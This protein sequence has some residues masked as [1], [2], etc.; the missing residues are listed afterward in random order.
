M[1]TEEVQIILKGEFKNKQAVIDALKGIDKGVKD[2][3][4]QSDKT[5]KKVNS[6]ESSLKKLAK[7]V[8]LSILAK[9]FIDLGK[10][11]LTAAGQM[12]QYNVAFTTMLGSAEKAKNLMEEAIEFAAK[13]PFQLDGVLDATKQLLAYQVAQEEVLPTLRNLGDI[14]AGTGA[15]L[16]LIAKA[17]GDIKTKGKL[18]GQEVLQL[19]NANIPIIKELAKTFGLT[20]TEI[21]NM[22]AKGQI[23]FEMVK[24]AIRG[25][26]AEGG[27]FFNLMDEQSKTFL[28]TVSNMQDGFF[29]LKVS[30][31]N[32]LLPV[33][34]ETVNKL[35]ILFDRLTKIVDKNKEKIT[36]FARSFKKAIGAGIEILSTFI[37]GIKFLISV[38]FIKWLGLTT[39]AVYAL[40]KALILIT[41][42]PILFFIISI[43]QLIG[44]TV[45]A[46]DS[47]LNGTGKIP[48]IFQKSLLIAAKAF[49]EL[50]LAVTAAV[51]AILEKLSF[52]SK[53]PGFGWVD[54]AIDKFDK[55][56]KS[57]ID[58]INDIQT[59]IDK[60]NE[61]KFDAEDEQIKDVETPEAKEAKKDNTVAL[62]Q[63]ENEELL[64]LEENFLA[65]KISLREKEAGI[66]DINRQER[67]AKLNQ[68]YADKILQE[69]LTNEQLLALRQEHFEA[70]REINAQKNEDLL[71]AEAD[72]IEG[73]LTQKEFEAE[74]NAIKR[75]E[76][77]ALLREDMALRLEDQIL[78]NE[79]R[80][81]L[82]E[83][84]E[85]RKKGI[86]DKYR[87]QKSVADKLQ[88]AIDIKNKQVKDST[89]WKTSDSLAKSLVGLESNKNSQLRS[90]GKA[91]GQFQKAQALYGI[92]V[93][94]GKGAISAYSSLAPIP[95]IGPALGAAAA[96]AVVAYGLQQASEVTGA[97]FA[98][99]AGEI[100]QDMQAQL[101]AGE[102][103]IPASFAESIRAGDLSIGG[104]GENQGAVSGETIINV[105]FDGANFYGDIDDDIVIDIGNR[106]GE[107]INENILS[108]IPTGVA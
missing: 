8:G 56:K 38:P 65:G 96:A 20:T 60:L 99:G 80:L 11:S 82:K 51:G 108:P 106:I 22:Q 58:D 28:G 6:L 66:E 17:Y 102:M 87:E 16:R 95:I 33:A 35:I 70:E 15:D 85:E 101:H 57:S 91:M 13:T 10:A 1:A 63:A 19:A 46:I 7:I 26:T 49:E 12:Q 30:I 81:A 73:K 86:D 76:E 69:G 67:L 37:T 25:M 89:I 75:E 93:E 52:L 104:G 43:I 79:T 78:D 23:S 103:V 59:A 88:D 36:D 61:R 105:N 94:T 21:Q 98:V 50:K 3:G 14:S 44:L 74:T 34:Q 97:S 18:A 29:Q 32:A 40:R 45:K 47:L 31:G 62:K 100:P 107:L 2:V 42:T 24:Q 39:V 4:T 48:T 77:L 41:K 54:G 27:T 92:T 9:K 84:F 72:F 64:K 53:V 55:L 5:K 71:Q 68:E 90:I 83:E